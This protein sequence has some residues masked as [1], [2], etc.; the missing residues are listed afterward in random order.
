MKFISI[1]NQQEID[2]ELNMSGYADDAEWTKDVRV[3]LKIK[4]ASSTAEFGFLAYLK[5]GK[6]DEIS[7]FIKELHTL[8]STLKGKA[9]LRLNGAEQENFDERSMILSLYSIDSLGH[10][11]AEI[12][13]SGSTRYNNTINLPLGVTVAF[14]IAS[15]TIEEAAFTIEALY[16]GVNINA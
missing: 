10:I 15:A 7:E 8:F 16:E 6:D 3:F 4:G 1:N 14:E 11:A 9:E 5:D 13:I 12:T 2:L